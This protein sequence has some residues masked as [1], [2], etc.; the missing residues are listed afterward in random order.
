MNNLFLFTGEETFLMHQQAQAWKE[1]F[2]KRY[3]NDLNLVTLDGA[4]ATASELISQIETM[5]FLADKRLIFIENLP[6]AGKASVKEGGESS[7]EE[8]TK[9]DGQRLADYLEKI[10]ETS[11]VVFVQPKPDKRKGLY[12]KIIHFATVKEF[13]PLQPAALVQWIRQQAA[14]YKA[15]ISAKVAEH[16]A[17]TAGHD[18]WRLDQEVKKLASFMEGKPIS[19]EAIDQLVTPS[20]EANIFHFTDALG[21]KD[22]RKAIRSL[23]RIIAAGENL[24]QT[25]YMIVRQFRLLLQ[26]VAYLQNYPN[27]TAPNLASSL[28]MNPFVARNTLGQAKHFKMAELKASYQKLLEIDLALKTSKIQTTTDNQD[29]L[30]MAIEQFILEFCR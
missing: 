3:D 16:L 19:V 6:E 5:P 15:S 7:E 18:L 13:K 21:A 8:E 26:V 27:T 10:P 17:E 23:H 30:A 28:K 4:E 9:G 22:S 24:R 2:R 29:E 20:L 25:F 14:T 1:T 12:K 11:V